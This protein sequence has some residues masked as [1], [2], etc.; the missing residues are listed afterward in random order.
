MAWGYLLASFIRR[1][2]AYITPFC[3]PKS[4][5]PSLMIRYPIGMYIESEVSTAKGRVDC[6]VQTAERIYV[7]EFK[8]DATAESGLA[9]IRDKRY[10][11]RLLETGIEVLALGVNFS[12]AQKALGTS[13]SP[14]LLRDSASKQ[15]PRRTSVLRG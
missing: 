6:V 14:D 7:I 12:T 13:P 2:G 1:P 10:G 9:Q 11:S 4:A 15:K 3:S 5:Y 8:L